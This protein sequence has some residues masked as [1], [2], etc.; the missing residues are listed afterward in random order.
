LNLEE[1][2][3]FVRELITKFPTFES[4]AKDSPDLG[5]THRGWIAAWDDL[6]LIE[7]REALAK[8]IKSGGIGYEDYRGPGPFIRRLVL[9]DRRNTP[10]SEDELVSH[11]RHQQEAAKRRAEYQ[12]LPMDATMQ[13]AYAVGRAMLERGEPMCI[14]HDVTDRIIAGEEIGEIQQAFRSYASA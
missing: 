12:K 4:V 5:A 3:Q 11:A 9:A 8:L 14:V 1:G 6:T 10:M 2:K 13:R 7:C